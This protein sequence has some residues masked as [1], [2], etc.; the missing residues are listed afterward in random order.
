[1]QYKSSPVGLLM[2]GLS[3]GSL[4]CRRSLLYLRHT[5]ARLVFLARNTSGK[6][7][8]NGRRDNRRDGRRMRH[9]G[10]GWGEEKV[11]LGGDEEN[12]DEEE[13][14]EGRGS[15]G[16]GGGGDKSACYVLAVVR[17]GGG[18]ISVG[19]GN[20]CGRSAIIA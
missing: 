5:N 17:V 11:E 9:R 1:M 12:R 4:A 3:E 19:V 18:G 14:G 2:L 7:L 20:V 10:G 13:E 8:H 15:G 6:I 16:G